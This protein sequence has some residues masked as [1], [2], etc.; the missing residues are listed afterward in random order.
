M[1]TIDSATE[2]HFGTSTTVLGVTTNERDNQIS[3]TFD[4]ATETIG[5]NNLLGKLADFFPDKKFK[6]ST[7]FI[8]D[9]VHTYVQNAVDLCKKALTS[10]KLGGD[11][12]SRYVFLE[13]LV[14]AGCSEWKVQNELLN[15]F[16]AGLDTTGQLAELVVLLSGSQ[17]RFLYQTQGGGRGSWNRSTDI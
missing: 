4:C 15:I 9:Y 11:G 17:T 7:A 16:L 1:L 6:D 5:F 12:S 8:E 2:F 13:Q 14:K 3:E 10:G